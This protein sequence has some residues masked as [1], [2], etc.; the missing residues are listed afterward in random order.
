MRAWFRPT[1]RNTTYGHVRHINVLLS[2]AGSRVSPKFVE[3]A[4]TYSKAGFIV[5]VP[6]PYE[7]VASFWLK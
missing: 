5:K 7:L 2:K 1:Y 4:L 6:T 3:I